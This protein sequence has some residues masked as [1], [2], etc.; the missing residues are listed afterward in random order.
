MGFQ[1]DP[2]SDINHPRRIYSDG[3][4]EGDT[5]DVGFIVG[6]PTAEAER[7]AAAFRTVDM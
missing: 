7:T 4:H 2:K 1:R 6:S 3:C 5:M